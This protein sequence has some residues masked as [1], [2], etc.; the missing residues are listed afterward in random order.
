MFIVI[1][2][3]ELMKKDE[4]RD[5]RGFDATFTR[6]KEKRISELVRRRL[7]EGRIMREE[8]EKWNVKT[9]S[10]FTSFYNVRRRTIL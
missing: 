5:S 1:M 3:V 9:D 6:H 4:K 8:F 7:C 10:S 2:V